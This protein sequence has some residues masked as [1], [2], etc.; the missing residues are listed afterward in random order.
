MPEATSYLSCL[1][2][3]TDKERIPEEPLSGLECSLAW[4]VFRYEISDI[5]L[6]IRIIRPSTALLLVLVYEHFYVQQ[7]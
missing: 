2:L 3:Q 7:I 4:L 5:F 6:T 1:Q